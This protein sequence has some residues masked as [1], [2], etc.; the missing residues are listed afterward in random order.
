MKTKSIPNLIA[1][2]LLVVIAGFGVSL[3]T[4][5]STST[6]AANLDEIVIATEDYEKDRKGPVKFTHFKHARDYKIS[7]W[8]CHHDYDGE[9][10][11]WKPWE[12]ETKCIECHD[13]DKAEKDPP[14][15]HK[16]FHLNCRGCHKQM[17]EKGMKTGPYRQCYGCHEKREK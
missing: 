6:A 8:E 13:T 14:N 1:F 3:I 7:C 15:L 4:A 9:E 12:G 16:A 5:Q 11:N 17:E 2:I 10:N